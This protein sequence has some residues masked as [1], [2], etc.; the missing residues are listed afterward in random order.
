MNTPLRR[1]GMARILK[2]SHSYLHTP[3]SSANEMNILAFA[4]P[5]EVGSHWGAK[6]GWI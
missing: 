2:G 1:S 5:A 4:F 3:R 6:Y